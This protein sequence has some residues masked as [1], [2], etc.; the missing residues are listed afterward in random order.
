MV[1]IFNFLYNKNGCDNM[2]KMKDIYEVT[3]EKQDHFGSGISKINGKFVFVKGA[4]PK[5]KVKIEVTNVKKKFMNAKIKE[6]EEKSPDRKIAECPYCEQCGGCQIMEQDYQSQLKFK[7]EKVRELFKKFAKVEDLKIQ[8]I[9][10]GKEFYYRNKAVFHGKSK[11]L[12]FYQEKTNDLIS[13]HECIL[14]E[15]DINRVYQK[16]NNYLNF[17]KKDYLDS[18]IIR[19]TSL[20][21]IIVILQGKIENS[22]QFI[23]ELEKLSICSIFLNHQ[24]IYG[25]EF[26][27][28][29]IFDFKF[30][31]LKNAFF[32]V[33]YKMM[34]EL[35]QLVINYYMKR[36]NDRVLDL[37]CG[38]GTI[39]M[40]VAPYVKEVIGIEVV[41]D[42]ILSA[43]QNKDLNQVSNIS[44]VEGK[45]EDK[46]ELFQEID[47]IIIDPP[48]SGLDSKT[49]QSI[50]EINPESIVYISCDPVT[51]TRDLKIMLK[52][53]NLIETHLVDMFPNTYHIE[54]VCVLNRRKSL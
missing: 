20:G 53:Y 21:E 19:K 32:Q 45:V 43:N 44:F 54:C 2:E 5:E 40:L 18:L 24:K 33:N 50:L 37:Y 13:V 34:K 48:R 27:T 17:N 15:E 42:S 10:F 4:L 1:G 46:I 29:Q 14:V 23:S 26:I 39:G 51:L 9:H 3:I 47:S 31:I 25:K 7:E 6:I 41:K 36:E 38:T 49:I 28:E 30:H 11:S 22:K 8:S 52:K 35:Y 16:I 12:G